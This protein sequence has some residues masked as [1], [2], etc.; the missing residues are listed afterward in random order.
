MGKLASPFQKLKIIEEVGGVSWP[1]KHLVALL[2][3]RDQSQSH[4]YQEYDC[5]YFQCH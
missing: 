4:E 1:E 3:L 5:S 2:S